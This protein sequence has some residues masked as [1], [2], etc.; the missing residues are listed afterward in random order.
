M[1]GQNRQ[2]AFQLARADHD[3]VEQEQELH[4]NTEMTRVIEDLV[5]EIHQTVRE[6]GP[7]SR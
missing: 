2:A 5:R 6:P 3:F 4:L 1:I 7:G